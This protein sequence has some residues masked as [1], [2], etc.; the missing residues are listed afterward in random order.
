MAALT[1]GIDGV[2]VTPRTVTNVE[3]IMRHNGVYVMHL[4]GYYA[5]GFLL[6]RNVFQPHAIQE[7]LLVSVILQ[8]QLQAQFSGNMVMQILG[9]HRG[10]FFPC[11][12][13]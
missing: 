6:P 2:F 8:S 9:Q 3:L 4:L 5:R 12:S 13:H 11:C 1:N 7:L 10:C